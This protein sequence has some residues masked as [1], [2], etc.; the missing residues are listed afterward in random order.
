MH[1]LL[2]IPDCRIAEVTRAGPASI[3]IKVQAAL[4]GACCPACH[5]ASQAVHSRYYRHPAD[6]ASF[7]EAVRLD[8]LVRRFY[9]RNAACPR[10]TFA[11]PLP[12]L[13]VPRA[14]RTR[15]L[16]ATQGGVGVACGG[17]AGARLLQR[18]GM[19]TSADTVLRL[20]RAVP[21]PESGMPRA[22]G[23][24]DWARRKGHTYGTILVDLEAR[25][26]VDLLP[27]R[28]AESLAAWLKERGSVEVITRDRSSE[29]T[30]GAAMGAP[31][32]VQVCDR[33]HLLQNLRE[34]IERWLGGIH[35]RLR[36]LPR[37]AGEQAVPSRPIPARARTQA[38][39]AR[40]AGSRARRLAHYEE[41]RRRFGAGEKL[42]AT[43]RATGLS[44]PTVRLY[45]YAQDF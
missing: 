15:R 35:G 31:K 22:L 25:R 17:E 41:V 12:N 14:R 44:R 45:A 19:P 28:T 27:D 40:S 16:V 30:R 37:V 42:L 39:A 34:M 11:E 10:L 5:T 7:G 26:V 32:A 13:L 24:D 23:V 38:E 33:W 20:V 3:H 36:R 9:C 18:L 8:V 29:Y 43:S 1:E 6:L 4:S 2:L 21:L